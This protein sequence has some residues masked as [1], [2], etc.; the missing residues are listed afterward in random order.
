MSDESLRTPAVGSLS[1]RDQLPEPA[2]FWRWVG[3][4][5]RPMVGWV[6]AGLGLI[7]IIVGWYG[8]SGQALV[9]KQLPYLI[10]GGLGGVA[11]VGVGAAL[12]GT[13]RMRADAARVERLEEMVAELRSVLL[14]Y[15]GNA[16]PPAGRGG[17][18]DTAPRADGAPR[19]D[20][21]PR[22]N[23]GARAESAASS[24]G[25]VVALPTG[26]TYHQPSC[27]MVKGKAG[28]AAVTAQSVRQRG[29]SACR[30]C[31]PATPGG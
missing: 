19:A 6:L 18:P 9:A 17:R 13:E 28:V 14:V 12:I 29:L 31:D 7:V 26:T 3:Q 20:V 27:T 22:N 23:G 2:L 8:I 25:R 21:A 16:A 1:E 24:D 11:L 10:S 5:T 4:S 15:P 30:I